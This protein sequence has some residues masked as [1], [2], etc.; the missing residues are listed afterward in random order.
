M[1]IGN[2][3]VDALEFVRRIDENGGI[4]AA[5]AQKAVLV[6][7]RFQGAHGG[8][9]DGDDPPPLALGGIDGL[10]R[11]LAHAVVFGV[12][13]VVRQILLLDGAEGTQSDVQQNLR[14]LHPHALDFLQKLAGKMQTRG[15]RGGG[16]VRLAIHRLI[17]VFVLQFFMDIR[18]ERHGAD[19]GEN[20]LEYAVEMKIDD[21]LA[22]LRPVPDSEGK[23]LGNDELGADFRLFARLYEHFPLGE[24][25]PLQEQNLDLAAVFRVR[26][27]ARGQNLGVVD[28]EHVARL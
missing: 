25:A 26:V 18:R 6:R 2:E 16:A 27:H 20:I 14:N 11:L 12:H 1:E 9:A 10:R 23:L 13:D 8:G 17:A 28:D 3:R 5:R 4:A 24:V 7:D 15:G 19:A 22:R 21:A